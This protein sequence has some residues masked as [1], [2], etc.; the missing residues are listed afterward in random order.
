[1]DFAFSPRVDS[2]RRQLRDFMDQHVLP[3][4]ALWQAEVHAGQLP[5]SFMADLQALARARATK[6][7]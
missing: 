2:L 1:M 5:V 3:R 6:S 7:G 4:H